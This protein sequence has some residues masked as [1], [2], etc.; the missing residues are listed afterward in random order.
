MTIFWAPFL[1]SYQP[2]WQDVDV[3]FRIYNECYKPLMGMMERHDNIKIT[4]NIQGG[5]LN[6]LAG[7][8]VKE[9]QNITQMIRNVQGR[10][11]YQSGNYWVDSRVQKKKSK[12]V[13]RIQFGGKKYFSFLKKQPEAGQF[14]ALGRN[15]RFVMNNRVYEVYE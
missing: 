5:L 11:F 2:P 15:V 7:L 13:V 3:L 9:I 1:H 6:S 10:A 14:L 8:T 12:K 4:M